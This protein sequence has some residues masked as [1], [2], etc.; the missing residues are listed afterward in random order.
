MDKIFE[1]IPL[2]DYQPVIRQVES[3]IR[4]MS[5]I[6]DEEGIEFDWSFV[7]SFDQSEEV[8]ITRRTA[9]N[10][11]FDFGINLY[12]SRPIDDKEWEA[13]D[14]R[15][16]FYFAIQTA[17]KKYGYEAIEDRASAIRVKFFDQ[18][19]KNIVH[20]LDFAIF[21]D[22]RD[23]KGM[24]S[25]KYAKKYKNGSY[26]WST[27]GGNNDATIEKLEWLEDNIGDDGD[28]SYHYHY[29]SGYSLSLELHDEYLRLKNTDQDIDKSSFQLYDEAVTNIYNLWQQRIK[30][31]K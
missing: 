9:G 15:N 12:V 13:K 28:E 29:K 7:G 22:V 27:H 30:E 18:E 5:K 3:C 1:Y 8:F 20:C 17:F 6:I 16:K 23:S 25:E 2:K 14:L 10:K 19:D 31:S 11:G 21:Q 4:K 26:V 24:L